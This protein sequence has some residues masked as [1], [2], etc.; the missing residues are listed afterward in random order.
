LDDNTKPSERVYIFP[1]PCL[2]PWWRLL[3]VETP[4]CGLL[5]MGYHHE[6]TTGENNIH[7]LHESSAND[8]RKRYKEELD[9]YHWFW[10]SPRFSG[11]LG[12]S[13][14]LVTKVGKKNLKGFKIH[15]WTIKDVNTVK[16]R[17]SRAGCCVVANWMSC[18]WRK[19]DGE[20]VDPRVSR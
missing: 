7:D 14:A 3:V 10:P 12:Q 15:T 17:L 20:G 6:Q 1:F 5:S 4:L 2:Y 11:W 19:Q 8:V 13:W 16:K 9:F 18:Q